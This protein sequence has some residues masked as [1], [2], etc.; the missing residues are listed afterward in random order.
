MKRI[1]E[2][3][4]EVGIVVPIISLPDKDL[5]QFCDSQ[6]EDILRDESCQTTKEFP[7]EDQVA[8][9]TGILSELLTCM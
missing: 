4:V 7:E 8:V 9:G 3:L 2:A 1:P 5:Q 6:E